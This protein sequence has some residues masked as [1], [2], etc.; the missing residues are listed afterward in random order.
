M[1]KLSVVVLVA[2]FA[3]GCGLGG[4]TS[5]Q[6]VTPLSI[7]SVYNANADADADV[8]MTINSV[9]VNGQAIGYKTFLE[10][11]QLDPGDK[12]IKFKTSGGTTVVDTAFTLLGF[13]A[14]SIFLTKKKSGKLVSVFTLDEGNLVTSTNTMVR[15]INLSP[16]SPDV[17]VKFV[18]QPNVFASNMPFMLA[19]PYTEIPSSDYAVQIVRSSDGQLLATASLSSTGS[20]YYQ[21]IVFSGYNVSPVGGAN[22][23]TAKVIHD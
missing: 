3:A 10:Y 2:V 15:F 13:K 18:G 22:T 8:N 19:G 9:Q 6:V 20:G 4:G 21:T 5:D 23:L 17:D 7:L 14:Y 1:K 16:D 12:A 11:F